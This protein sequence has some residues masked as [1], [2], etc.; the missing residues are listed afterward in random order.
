MVAAVMGRAD[1]EYVRGGGLNAIDWQ[2]TTTDVRPRSG[3][4][5]RRLRTDTRLTGHGEGNHPDQPG[6]W[7]AGEEIPSA[8][9]EQPGQLSRS[10]RVTG[11]QA[12][13]EDPGDPSFHR[14]RSWPVKTT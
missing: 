9:A 5:F 3:A 11:H 1:P 4:S 6:S 13:E 2:C 14:R 7:A 8:A 10:G 12:G